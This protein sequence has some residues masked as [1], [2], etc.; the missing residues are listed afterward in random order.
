MSSITHGQ[1]IEASVLAAR[2][3][4]NVVAGPDIVR[5][6]FATR[7]IHWS[8]A[9]TFF[10]CVFT[11]MPIWIPIFGWMA[12][13]VGGLEVARLIHPYSGVLFFIASLFQY[14]HWLPDMHFEKD[15]KGWLGPKL[16]AYL[17]WEQDPAAEG[18]KYN[19]GQKV[20]FY[21]VSL[22]ALVM[23]LSGIPMWFPTAWP[24]WLREISYIVHD[25]TFAGFFCA[26]V[27]HIYLGTAAEPGT[28][29]AMTIGTVTRAWARFHHPQWYREVTGEEAR[30]S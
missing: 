16:I 9:L 12:A 3:R 27:V 1:H 23:L 4:D 20:F 30:K 29:R 17:R 15:Q 18:G 14:F 6:R 11:G 24:A 19:G 5:H 26:I 13:F 25:I 28:F 21:I 2:D 7:L 10:L 8:V 22:S